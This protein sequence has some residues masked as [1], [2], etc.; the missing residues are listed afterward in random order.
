MSFKRLFGKSKTDYLWMGSHV[1][2]SPKI[3]PFTKAWMPKN[4]IPIV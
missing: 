2:V 1:C 3:A 4:A